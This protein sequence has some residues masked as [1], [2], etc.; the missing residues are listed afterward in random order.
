M[1]TTLADENLRAGLLKLAQYW[2][3]ESQQGN[4]LNREEHA[5]SV[6]LSKCAHDLLKMIERDETERAG[7]EGA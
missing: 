1:K 5:Q 7:S 3:R 2:L 4:P 6:V